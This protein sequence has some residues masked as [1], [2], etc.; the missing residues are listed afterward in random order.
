MTTKVNGSET[1]CILTESPSP[2]VSNVDLSAVAA[3]QQYYQTKPGRKSSPAPQHVRSASTRV[4]KHHTPPPAAQKE[5]DLPVAPADDEAC[6]L[7]CADYI[8]KLI[9]HSQ[10][11]DSELSVLF[12]EPPKSKKQPKSKDE[13]RG[14]PEATATK[15]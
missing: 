14:S 4:T 10:K 12:D 9:Y 15:R 3:S 7:I 8:R 13:V 6:V 1:V 11:S 2:K 5:R